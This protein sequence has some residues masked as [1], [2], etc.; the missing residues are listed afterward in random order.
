[1]RKRKSVI[2]LLDADGRIEFTVT[3]DG[4]KD[5]LCWGAIAWRGVPILPS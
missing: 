4:E 1:M 3:L 2:G 5:F